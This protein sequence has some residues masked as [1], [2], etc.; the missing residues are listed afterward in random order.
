MDK[1]TN[2]Q[3]IRLS[4]DKGTKRHEYLK[5]TKTILAHEDGRLRPKHVVFQRG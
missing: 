2:I 3:G 1:R 5:I 4:E